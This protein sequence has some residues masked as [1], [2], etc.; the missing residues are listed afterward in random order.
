M[1]SS[2]L[3]RRGGHPEERG[4]LSAIHLPR[5]K[6]PGVSGPLPLHGAKVPSRGAEDAVQRLCH[7]TQILVCGDLSDFT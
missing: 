4:P 3:W 1:Y 2:R 6:W 7:V 5:H